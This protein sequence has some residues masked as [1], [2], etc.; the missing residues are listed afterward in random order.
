MKDQTS[1]EIPAEIEEVRK[2]FE[3]WRRT[4]PKVMPI[5]EELWQ[6]A[7]S[8]C[9]LFPF[10]Q[11]ASYLHLN[12]TTLKNRLLQAQHSSSLPALSSAQLTPTFVQ[13][14]PSS[15]FAAPDAAQIVLEFTGGD[16]ARLTARLPSSF[17]LELVA[18]ADS[19]WRRNPCCK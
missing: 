18:L 5:P 3:D 15:L 9:A 10:T 14:S 2:R 19:F 13:L 6:A 16:G 11:V 12:S 1:K 8:L 4:R 17:P 7:L